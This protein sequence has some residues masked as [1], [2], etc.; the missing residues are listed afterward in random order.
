MNTIVNL[1]SGPRNLSTALMYSFAQHSNFEVLDEPF[2][3]YYLK[4]SDRKEQHPIA[5]EIMESMP[6]K[7]NEIIEG[8]E[9]QATVKNVFVKGMAHHIL[10]ES[11]DFLLNWTN[12][13]LIRKPQNLIASFSKKI[14]EPT[15]E[16]IGYQ[17]A[18]QLFRYL[19]EHDKKPIVIDSGELMKNPKRYLE[20]LFEE[21]GL[22][23][24]ENM[25]HWSVGGIV[26]DGIWASYW[27]GS[28]HK[29][30]GFEKQK[31]ADVTLGKRLQKLVE[32]AEPLY[33]SLYKH[34]LKND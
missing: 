19:R 26:E 34:A 12:V 25:L 28:V 15:L 27:Y 20:L 17:K 24:R 6:K 33:N 8:I 5:D 10:P 2:Y 7:L 18:L 4:H 21:I 3:G 23:F 29:S 16:D 1:L 14:K 22:P 30:T 13:I 9:N 32:E 11:P 31:S